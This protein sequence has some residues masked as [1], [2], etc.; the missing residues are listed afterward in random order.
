MGLV[1]RRLGIALGC[2]AAIA[3]LIALGF[4]LAQRWLGSDDARERLERVLSDALG[5]AV[6]IG[7]LEVDAPG[8]SVDLR[9]VTIASGEGFAGA[10]LLRAGTLHLHVAL[11]RLL[12]REVVGVVQARALDLHVAVQGGRTNLEGLIGHGTGEPVDLHLD[13][14]IEASRV[15]IEDVDRAESLE[16]DGVG[17]RALLSNRAAERSADATVSI[18]R[19][20]LHANELNEVSFVAS[21]RDG[22]LEIRE[23]R[24]TPGQ[25][26]SVTGSGRARWTGARDWSFSL[27]AEGVDLA[28]EVVPLVA[29]VYPLLAAVAADPTAPVRGE[30]GATLELRGRG[31]HWTSVRPTLAGRGSVSLAKLEIPARSLV[32]QLAELAGRPARPLTVERGRAEIEIA[33]DWIALGRVE[34]EGAPFTLPVRGRVS[35][36]GELD[37]VVDLMPAVRAF[38]GGVYA[39]VARTTSSL[40]VRVR[41]T[42]DAPELAPPTPGDVARGLVGGLILRALEPEESPAAPER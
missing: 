24:A 39:A 20:G 40:P 30:A 33:D 16:L 12:D 8:G 31:F 18:A 37:L 41:G 4:A 9:N 26:G 6:T 38:G 22:E 23:L 28:G 14:E 25:R 36:G 15:V 7:A 11:D 19:V 10:P 29:A 42:T 5:R 2:V 17:L 34:I 27:A 32:L 13:L 35:L 21:A 1:R 3:A